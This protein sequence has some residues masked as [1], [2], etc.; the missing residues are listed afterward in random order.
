L[1]STFT[2]FKNIYHSAQQ[3]KARYYSHQ[4]TGRSWKVTFH[5]QMMSLCFCATQV[6]CDESTRTSVAAV[7][8][9]FWLGLSLTIL[10]TCT[11]NP[12]WLYVRAYHVVHWNM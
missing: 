10:I 11:L 12:S 1:L 8:V 5:I 2:L 4:T 3:D 7:W 9:E 6:L